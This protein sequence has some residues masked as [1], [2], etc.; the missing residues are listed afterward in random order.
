VNDETERLERE[1]FL[2]GAR[3]IASPNFDERP[4]QT[5]VSLIVIHAISLPPS[6]FGGDD[7][8]LFFTNRLD[9]EKHPYFAEIGA[10]RVS[11]HYLIRRDGAL[12]Q[13]VACA[14]RAWHAGPSSWK[15]R[16]RCN[17][18]SIGIELEGCDDLPFENAQYDRLDDLIRFIFSRHP[19][20]AIAGHADISPGRKTD[21]GRFFEWRRLLWTGRTAHRHV[22]SCGENDMSLG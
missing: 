6:H 3:A 12:I 2:S 1:A 4:P 14:H 7:I 16:T 11:A 8:L 18:F 20:D 5:D 19:I 15:G 13:F 9:P 17:D 21:P 10:L 22:E